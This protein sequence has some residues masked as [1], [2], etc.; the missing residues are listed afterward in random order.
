MYCLLFSTRDIHKYGKFGPPLFIEDLCIKMAS[1]SLA[2][3][4]AF[5]LYS[6][7]EFSDQYVPLG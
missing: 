6:H 7:A 5:Y 1:D 3:S 2:S 4:L